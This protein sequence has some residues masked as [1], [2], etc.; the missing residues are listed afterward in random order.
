MAAGFPLCWTPT[1]AWMVPEYHFAFNYPPL[2]YAY[3]LK[4]L[5]FYFVYFLFIFH[6]QCQMHMF[7]ALTENCAFPR[8]GC[9]HCCWNWRHVSMGS[10]IQ[11]AY[12]IQAFVRLAYA[13]CVPSEY[14]SLVVSNQIGCMKPDDMYRRNNVYINLLVFCIPF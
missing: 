1:C 3:L 13:V 5:W 14:T 10:L 8:S 6:F 11:T 4:F 9:F 2:S 7:F 12:L